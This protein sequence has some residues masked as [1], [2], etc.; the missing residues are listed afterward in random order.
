MLHSACPSPGTPVLCPRPS[1]IDPSTTEA[2]LQAPF[3]FMGLCSDQCRPLLNTDLRPSSPP[4]TSLL[5][6][7]PAG[8]KS[9]SRKT[10]PLQLQYWSGLGELV[11]LDLSQSTH[12]LY[13]PG[14]GFKVMGKEARKELRVGALRWK[15]TPI[16]AHL[17]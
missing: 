9:V 8:K 17:G 15:E 5:L 12:R 1:S 7:R 10:L 11:P 13:H 16:T 14:V 2:L 6:M 4:Q 3:A